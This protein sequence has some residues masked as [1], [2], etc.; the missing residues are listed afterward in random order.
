[1]ISP[2]VAWM[3]RMSWPLWRRVSLPCGAIVRRMNEAQLEGSKY[4]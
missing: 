3:V 1:M 2:V 4:T